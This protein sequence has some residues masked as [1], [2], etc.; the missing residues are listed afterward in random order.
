MYDP[1]IGR[2]LSPD[3]VVQAPGYTQSYNR[4]SYCMN[5][6][7]RYTDPSGWLMAALDE[8]WNMGKEITDYTSFSGSRTSGGGGGGGGWGGVGGV[9]PGGIYD[10]W[11]S[12]AVNQDTKENTNY[13]GQLV[14][15]IQYIPDGNHI[16]YASGK[17]Q[18]GMYYFDFRDKDAS[19][20]VQIQSDPKPINNLNG[21]TGLT[22]YSYYAFSPDDS[23]TGWVKKGGGVEF[24]IQYTET[25]INSSA[26]WVQVIFTNSPTCNRTSPYFDNMDPNDNCRYSGNMY[27]MGDQFTQ[28][29]TSGMYDSP[30]RPASDGNV[31]WRGVAM[32]WQDGRSLITVVYGFTTYNGVTSKYPIFVIH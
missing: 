19:T 12:W 15:S 8:C 6:P 21:V 25:E 22:L 9:V 27:Y 24:K 16:L 11:S 32:L 10:S 13:W 23:R 4:Y 30:S 3:K 20:E 18:N 7:L 5:N 14:G 26:K 1:I 28:G 2:V 29:N 17:D 31:S